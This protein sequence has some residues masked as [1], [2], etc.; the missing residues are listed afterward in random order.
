MFIPKLYQLQ[1]IDTLA[2]F[3]QRTR[4]LGG[5]AAAFTQ[6]TSERTGVG[7][8]YYSAPGFDPADA[9]GMPYVCLRLPT[10][11]GKTLLACLAV[12]VVQREL[13]RSER[14]VVLWLV[15]SKAIQEQTLRALRDRVHPYRQALDAELGEV[16]VLDLAEA[17]YATQATYD[18]GTVIL[19]STLQAFRVTEKEGRKV[20]ESS[21]ALQ[22]HFSG[23]TAEVLA[24]LEKT[25]TGT[26]AYSLANVLRLRR[27]MVIVDEAHNARTT[28]SFD[29]LARF[30]P[31]CIL[32]LT[33]TPATGEAPSNVL[34]HVS[35]RQLAAED[36]IK[37]PIRL[38]TRPDWEQLLADAV[39]MREGLE[40]D[41]RAEEKISGEA[42]RPIMLIKAER[43]DKARETLT[44]DVVEKA[45]LEQ[46]K[47]PADWVVRATGD[48]RGLDDVDLFAP[49]CPV[50]FVITVDA[51]KEGWDCA[52]AY[53]LCSVAE[54][55]SDTA[56]EQIVGRVLRLP[57]ARRKQTPSLNRAY[58]FAT[59]TNFSATA[60]AL[61]DALVEGNGFNPLE[62][63]DLIV[64]PAATQSA[65]ELPA[66]RT[67]P[68]Q[69]LSLGEVP[70]TTKWSPA[71]SAK[72]KVDAKVGTVTLL[73][74]LTPE[75]T[76]QAAASFVMDTHRESFVAAVNEHAKRTEQVFTSPAERGVR[77]A[78]PMLCLQRQGVFELLDET[79]FLERPWSL[80]DYLEKPV[81]A[82]GAINEAQAG[83]GEI[84]L[85]EKGKV[86]WKFGHELAEQLKLIDVTENW[87][88]ARLVDWFDRNIPH[89]DLGADET[90][91]YIA[92]LVARWQQQGW[93]LGR[94]VR[95]RFPLRA[96]IEKIIQ[97][98][99]LDAK[100]RAYQE[101]LFDSVS[102]PITVNA[103]HV[104]AF[105]PDRYPAR[106]VCERSDDFRKHY[107]RQVGELG[108]E[109][110]E[111]ECALFLDTLPEVSVWVRNL[112]RQPEKSFWLP[113]STDRFYPDFVCKLRDGRI[114][115]V[116]YKGA[117]LATADDAK[118]KR[119][120]GQLWAER[121]GGTGLFVMPD[122]KDFATITKAIGAGAAAKPAFAEHDCVALA[123]DLVEDGVRFPAGTVGTVVSVYQDGKGYAVELQSVSG[124]PV[125][126][127]LFAH[128]VKP[129]P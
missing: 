116:E 42:I 125:V 95:E 74:P 43:R 55:K 39:A 35:A 13:L 46:C 49:D 73:A 10:G 78:V 92:N 48:E 84:A 72:V 68:P 52:W 5:P 56:V 124:N 105:D 115:V 15:P 79:H 21:G 107:H 120:L 32:E 28:L 54:M 44:V 57:K 33:A 9:A 6:L 36:M 127:T 31:S 70:E 81:D 106:W 67:A 29:T 60:R 41:A 62:A 7:L 11:G 100:V 88:E 27:P 87:T 26:T 97:A 18:A 51:L 65:L 126:A 63:K 111:F 89:P 122:G 19:V 69:T 98:C 61:E 114:L 76:M 80:R 66:T 103:E 83:Y 102:G 59:S 129:A 8:P 123:T 110:E 64:T 119:L 96:V 50:R 3:L 109:G 22:H 2:A 30:R 24:S 104:F 85:T 23:L 16:T 1:T 99:R 12:P 25:E 20:Y 90:G 108:S 82:P 121:S 91:V 14:G 75:E 112:E 4:E 113:T 71:L 53:V 34:A 17:L 128:Q 117:H 77:L 58:A 47:V 86:Q 94:L 40:R 93:P 37:L 118:E 45:L 101:V 38:E